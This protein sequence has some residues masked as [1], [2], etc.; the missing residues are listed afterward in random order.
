MSE[1]APATPPAPHP[2]V[3]V[4]SAQETLIEA[5]E[6]ELAQ[7]K[8]DLGAAASEPSVLVSDVK[9]IMAKYESDMIGKVHL[10]WGELKTLL[11]KAKI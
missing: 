4:V 7:V 11:A 10:A 9:A 3:A 2:L 5:I 8:A 1:A 6:K